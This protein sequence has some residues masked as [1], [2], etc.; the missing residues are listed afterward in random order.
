[1]ASSMPN[2]MLDSWAIKHIQ[3]VLSRSLPVLAH[4]LPYAIIIHSLHSILMT[5]LETLLDFQNKSKNF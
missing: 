2:T 1:M 4:I 3:I 5:N